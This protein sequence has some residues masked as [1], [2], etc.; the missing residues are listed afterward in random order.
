MR[1]DRCSGRLGGCLPRGVS[2]QGRVVCPGWGCLPSGVSA[3]GCLPRGCTPPPMDRMTD[4]CENITFQQPRLLMFFFRLVDMLYWEKLQ[5]GK[6]FQ[7]TFGQDT[8]G[9]LKEG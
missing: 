1:T 6:E 8:N 3:W 2:A 5:V 7:A 4:A 9:V